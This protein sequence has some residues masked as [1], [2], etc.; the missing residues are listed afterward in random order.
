MKAQILHENNRGKSFYKERDDRSYTN[1][2]TADGD[3]DTFER[4][5][6][7]NKSISSL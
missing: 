7:R 3:I 6:R 4:Y 2:H 5:Y 1:D